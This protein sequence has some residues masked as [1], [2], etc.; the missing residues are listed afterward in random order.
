MAVQKKTY[1]EY[2]VYNTIKM[3]TI[4][5]K[6]TYTMYSNRRKYTSLRNRSSKGTVSRGRTSTP[7]VRITSMINKK[8]FD[9]WIGTWILAKLMLPIKTEKKIIL[10]IK[11]PTINHR[12]YGKTE[13]PDHIVNDM[14]KNEDGGLGSIPLVYQCP[15]S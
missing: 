6:Y 11:N 2:T 14:N 10:E 9:I 8:S 1:L 3:K 4:V 13:A 12:C 5:Y 15:Q 7:I